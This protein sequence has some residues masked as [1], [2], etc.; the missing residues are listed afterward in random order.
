M[1]NRTHLKIL[2]HGV[3]VWNAWRKNRPSI[4]P[5]LSG[6]DL[7]YRNLN[8]INFSNTNLNQVNFTNADMISANLIDASIEGTKGL[9]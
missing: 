5:D 8:G 2:S 3:N 6:T 7:S 9:P 4:A 1:A